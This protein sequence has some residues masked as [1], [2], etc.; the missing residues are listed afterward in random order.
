MA[1]KHGGVAASDTLIITERA[2]EA[3]RMRK[4]GLSYQSIGDLLGVSDDTARRDV[5]GA[6]K[7]LE[8]VRNE[9]AL[10]VRHMVMER[11]N[12]AIRAIYERV[13]DGD[14]LAIDRMVKLNDQLL[15]TV[16][17]KIGRMD[18]TSGGRPLE[19][20]RIDTIEVVLSVPALPGELEDGE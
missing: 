17:G 7:Q 5:L 14:L 1:V 18:V 3:L 4:E 2:I 13:I 20:T 8:W 9:E 10:E 19:S 12:D 15:D 11:D 16:G 6:L